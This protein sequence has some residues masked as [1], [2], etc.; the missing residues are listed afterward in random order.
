MRVSARSQDTKLTGHRAWAS[1]IVGEVRDR[2]DPRQMDLRWDAVNRAGISHATVARFG[3]LISLMPYR[4]YEEALYVGEFHVI[5]SVFKGFR[6]FSGCGKGQCDLPRTR[7]FLSAGNAAT[8]GQR[9]SFFARV[10]MR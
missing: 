3:V 10:T 7:R 8:A 1:C 6:V 2:A 9:N 5:L 4:E